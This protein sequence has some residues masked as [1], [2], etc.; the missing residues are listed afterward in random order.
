MSIANTLPMITIFDEAERELAAF[1]C[2]ITDVVGR[3]GLTRASEF[4]IQVMENLDW[5]DENFEKFFR[6]VSIRAAAQ[7]AENFRSEPIYRDRAE[8][9]VR[10]PMLYQPT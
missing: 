4:W 8:F 6:V 10:T 5:P 3:N 2:A 7:L 9:F 1:L